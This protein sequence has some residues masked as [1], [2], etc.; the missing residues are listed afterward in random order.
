MR[1]SSSP[2]LHRAICLSLPALSL[3]RPPLLPLLPA[4]PPV[5]DSGFSV[6]ISPLKNLTAAF[7]AASASAVARAA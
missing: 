3:P 1:Q 2:S 7:L 6:V 4:H 5:L